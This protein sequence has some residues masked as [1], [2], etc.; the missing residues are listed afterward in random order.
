MKNEQNENV[1][2]LFPLINKLEQ[3]I[4]HATGYEIEADAHIDG[5]Y[6]LKKDVEELLEELNNGQ[7]NT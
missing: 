5:Y 6:Y 1:L 7:G 4:T 3:I 2:P